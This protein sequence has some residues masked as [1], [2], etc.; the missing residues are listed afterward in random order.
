VFEFVTKKQYWDVLDA[1]IADSILSDANM[2]WHLKSIQ[3]ALAFSSLYD[4]SHKSIAE[5]GGGVSRLLPTLAQRNTCFNI[6]E[7]KG[8]G[9][10]PRKES[11][12]PG[13]VNILK[14]VGDFST[15]IEDEKFD[16]IFSVSVVE[17]VPDAKLQDFFRDCH[18]MLK[19][20][21]G[22]MIHLIDVYLEDSGGDNALTARRVLRYGSCIDGGLF[23]YV[24]PPRIRTEQDVAFS[25]SY[26]TNPDNMMAQWNRS[27]PNLREKR[28]RAQSCTLR[29]IARTC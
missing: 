2:P 12:V 11:K 21:G 18:R 3:D 20:G 14:S 4:M 9:G 17:H 24:S 1:N 22:L 29:M 15:S 13:V 26:A 19:P 23:E 7:F 6:E 5:I 8:A 16:A 27:A 10:G 28:E 25:T